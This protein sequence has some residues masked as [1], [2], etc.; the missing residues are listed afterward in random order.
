MGSRTGEMDRD[1]LKRPAMNKT[2]VMA[3]SGDLLGAAASAALLTR[4]FAVCDDDLRQPARKDSQVA[5]NGPGFVG[6][7]RSCI[8]L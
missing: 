8:G 7:A 6:L 3:L 1:L 5:A 4:L 2:S